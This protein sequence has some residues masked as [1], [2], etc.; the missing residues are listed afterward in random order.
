METG[1]VLRR[2]LHFKKKYDINCQQVIDMVWRYRSP[3]P[4]GRREVFYSFK[5][6]LPAFAVLEGRGESAPVVVTLNY[7]QQYLLVCAPTILCH[8]FTEYVGNK[9]CSHSFSQLT[10]QEILVF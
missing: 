3:I 9:Y 10:L 8:N 2:S 7:L 5:I 1:H 6:F 4:V